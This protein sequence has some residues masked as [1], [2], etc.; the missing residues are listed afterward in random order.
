ML[1]GESVV[2][3]KERAQDQAK[4]TLKGLAKET[5]KKRPLKWE[6]YKVG[7]GQY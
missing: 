4:G 1:Q 3:K 5:E 2:V 6:E 7:A